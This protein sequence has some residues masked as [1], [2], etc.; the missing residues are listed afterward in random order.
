LAAPKSTGR[1]FYQ[2]IEPEDMSRDFRAAKAI[3]KSIFEICAKQPP[4]YER[5]QLK[6]VGTQVTQ[7]AG[8]AAEG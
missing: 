7:G 6:V 2:A 8:G 3:E 5:P 1:C 4:S